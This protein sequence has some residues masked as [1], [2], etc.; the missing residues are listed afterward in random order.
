MRVA[1]ILARG[2]VQ[3]L[4]LGGAPRAGRLGRGGQAL[5]VGAGQHQRGKGAAQQLRQRQHHDLRGGRV[6]RAEAGGFQRLADPTGEFGQAH[7]AL[8]GGPVAPVGQGFVTQAEGVNDGVAGHVGRQQRPQAA[9]M[10]QR[11][12]GGQPV[13]QWARGDHGGAQRFDVLRERLIAREQRGLWPAAHGVAAQAA[14]QRALLPRIEG[15][16][17]LEPV[18]HLVCGGARRAR[19]QRRH[20]L[21]GGVGG[22]KLPA[23][24]VAQLGTALDQ[25]RV[26]AAREQA[27]AGDQRHRHA[28]HLD[29][30]QHAG[31]GALGFVFGIGAGVQGDVA[32][33]CIGLGVQ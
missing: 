24:L 5:F 16:G 9:A 13:G 29:L 18:E 31:G 4:A 15:G 11:A 3:G 21:R 23:G 20:Q 7:A 33:R 26:D 30:A 12:Q 25:Q 14:F 19:V 1:Q 2:Q 32:Q 17:E 6:R 8:G 28:A 27:V 10:Q 22:G